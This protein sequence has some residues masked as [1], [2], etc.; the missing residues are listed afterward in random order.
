MLSMLWAPSFCE[1]LAL[2]C[3]RVGLV[4]AQETAGVPELLSC[5]PEAFAKDGARFVDPV[6][7]L[8]GGLFE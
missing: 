8:L 2:G 5:P 7:T 1:A 3:G 4:C 6:K